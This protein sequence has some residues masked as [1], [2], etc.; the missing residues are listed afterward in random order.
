MQKYS[1]ILKVIAA[2]SLL[3]VFAAQAYDKDGDMPVKHKKHHAEKMQRYT[4][5][6]GATYL[7][8]SVNG[9]DYA[10]ILRETSP[11]NASEH[12]EN[13]NPGYDWGYFLA[14]GY[15]ISKHY[16]LQASWSQYDS[17]DT[18]G[19]GVTGPASLWTSNL[20]EIVLAD[21]ET[22][23]ASTSESLKVQAFDA[24]L[25]QYHNITKMLTVRPFLGV[26]YAKV[27]SKTQN[28]YADAAGTLTGDEYNSTFSGAGPEVGFD[29]LYEVY[30]QLGVVGHFGTAFLIG[31][32]DT[33]SQVTAETNFIDYKGESET[34]MVPAIN[35]KLGLSWD[36]LYSHK[37]FGVG[38][39]G[40][41]QVA[42]YFN[43][44]NQVQAI[45]EGQ[46]DSNYSSVGV[47]GPYLNLSAKF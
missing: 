23:S 38:I 47:M 12:N 18:D 5:T 4:L 14:F 37:S 29:A 40:G 33:D 45:S 46:V 8:P 44:V 2:S 24:N 21:G 10:N 35:A 17:S 32:Q 41:Y 39:E 28:V 7:V 15:K 26:G 19:V 9:L 20:N 36:S 11:G 27:Q 1:R 25:G 34:R 42:Y 13:I 22:A 6:G 3:A 30:Q 16:D 31:N 43:A